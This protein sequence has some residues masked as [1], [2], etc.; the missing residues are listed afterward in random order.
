MNNHSHKDLFCFDLIGEKRD[1]NLWKFTRYYF[2][3]SLP[4]GPFKS[5]VNAA[6]VANI[7]IIV[8]MES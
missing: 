2:I 6:Y 3:F 5:L 7:T 4:L 1:E 8:K